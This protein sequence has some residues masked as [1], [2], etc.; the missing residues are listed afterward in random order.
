MNSNEQLPLRASL[1]DAERRAAIA[2]RRRSEPKRPR[3]LEDALNYYLY[4]PLAWR[5]AV[6]LSYTPISPNVVSIIGGLHVVAAAWVYGWLWGVLGWGWKAAL[7]GMG[8]HMAWHV[9]DGADGDLARITGKAS[10]MGE[11]IDGICDYSSHIILY[12]V[13]GWTMA[14]AVA[15][16]VAYPRTALCWVLTVLAGASHVVQANHCEVWRRSYQW[17]VYDKPWLRNS[18]AEADATTRKGIVGAFADGYLALAGSTSAGIAQI[19]AQVAAAERSPDYREQL[20]IAA[21]AEAPALLGSLKILGPNPRAIVLGLS[22]L[23]GS[24]KWYFLWQV[25]VLNLL[26]WMSVRSHEATAKRILRAAA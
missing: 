19:D 7:I 20:R 15:E 26:L 1:T 9:W 13:L 10:P 17:W 3:E 23:A 25:V 18:H 14:H 6:L 11:M 5:L 2:E 22:M 21:R 8:L 12:L 24:P 16:P 4:H